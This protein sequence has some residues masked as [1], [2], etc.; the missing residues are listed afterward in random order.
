MRGA[1]EVLTFEVERGNF[2]RVRRLL[3][4]RSTA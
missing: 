3:A 2:D 1:A 4:R